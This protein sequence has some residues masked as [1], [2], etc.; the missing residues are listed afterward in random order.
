[1]KNEMLVLKANHDKYAKEWVK[2]LDQSSGHY[3][4]VNNLRTKYDELNQKFLDLDLKIQKEG[5]AKF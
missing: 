2:D 1:M 5:E 4:E 3:I